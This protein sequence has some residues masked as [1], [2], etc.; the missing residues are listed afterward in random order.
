MTKI[1]PKNPKND[2]DTFET[3]KANKIPPDPKITKINTKPLKW[4]KYTRNIKKD[5]NTHDT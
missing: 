3:T 1:H 5:Q 2:R 4:P